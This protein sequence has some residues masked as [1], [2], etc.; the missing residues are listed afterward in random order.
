MV[1][2]T[3]DYRAFIHFP[4][5]GILKKTQK[6]TTFRKLD[7]VQSSG[8]GWETP[9]PLDTL[10]QWFSNFYASRTHWK[11]VCNWRTPCLDT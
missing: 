2:N 4:L 6:N 11:C 9:T 10:E 3:Q 7:L 1:Y 5:S 8:D